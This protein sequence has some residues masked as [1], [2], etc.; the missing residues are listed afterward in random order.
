MALSEEDKQEILELL[1]KEN[2]QKQQSVLSSKE[3]F[4]RWLSHVASKIVEK[5]VEA[6]FEALWNYCLGWL[7]NLF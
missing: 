3:S 4:K 1:R 2:E 7:P 5:L 6:A